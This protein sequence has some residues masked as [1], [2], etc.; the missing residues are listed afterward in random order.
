LAARSAVRTAV[1]VAPEDQV[2]TLSTCGDSSAERV[3]VVTKLAPV[4]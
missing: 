3:V 1:S 2:V 4:A